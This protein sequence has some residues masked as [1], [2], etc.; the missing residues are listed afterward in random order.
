MTIKSSRDTC[1]C[2]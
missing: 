2:T 1:T